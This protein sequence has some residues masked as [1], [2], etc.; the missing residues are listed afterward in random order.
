[1]VAEESDHESLVACDYGNGSLWAISIA[2]SEEAIR[3]QYP[4]LV[5][6]T[7]R[8]HRMEADRLE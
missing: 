2:P 7:E 3:S 8:P 1:M 4:E 6:A 5:S